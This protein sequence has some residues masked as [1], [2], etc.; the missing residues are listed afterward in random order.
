MRSLSIRPQL[1]YAAVLSAVV[2]AESAVLASRAY[3]VHPL[4]LRAAVIFDLCAVP[5]GLWWLLFVRRGKAQPRTTARVF[6]LSVAFAA[7]LFGRDV[8]LLAAPV[9]LFLM[10]L[11]FTSVRGAL[12][13]RASADAVTALRNGLVAALGDNFAARA[14]A[15]ELTAFWYAFFSYGA[16]ARA[17]ARDGFTAYKRAGWT[18]IYVAVALV[19]VG[20][21]AG[22]HFLLRRF[23][24]IATVSA[25]GFHLYALLWMLGDLRALMVRP[26]RVEEGT[27]HLRL[28]LRWEAEIPLSLVERVELS[29]KASPSAM[30]LA[31]I[32]SANL[33][34]LLRAPVV[35]HGPFGI[36]RESRDLLLQVDEPERLSARLGLR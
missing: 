12:R 20:E 7:L 23:G 27:M 32:G 14:A 24:P 5:A 29:P 33:R 22:V 1:S 6:V 8:R 2:A 31:V 35:L 9:E 28:G 13:A 34:L 15:G 25:A 3:S 16:A 30:R 17:A 10:Y 19:S 21:A 4:P 26:I 36:R 18:A 11:A